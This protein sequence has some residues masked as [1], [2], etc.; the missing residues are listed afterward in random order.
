MELIKTYIVDC[1]PREIS[2]DAPVDETS[3]IFRDRRNR[4]LENPPVAP[5][6]FF[7]KSFYIWLEN[8][9]KIFVTY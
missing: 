4:R 1:P 8:K 9:I 2:V 3:P 5:I 7:P 6:F